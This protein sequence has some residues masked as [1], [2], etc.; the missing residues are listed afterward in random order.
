MF[1]YEHYLQPSI[2]GL[3]LFLGLILLVYWYLNFEK[4]NKLKNSGVVSSGKIIDIQEYQNLQLDEGVTYTPIVEFKTENNQI[5]KGKLEASYSKQLKIGEEVEVFY[6]YK[7]P[8][9]FIAN[10][11]Y[12]TNTRNYPFLFGGLVCLII[13]VFA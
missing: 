1:G 3:L 8:N 9:D 6:N 7:D 5:I 2:R 13:G 12:E 4:I 11:H 10:T